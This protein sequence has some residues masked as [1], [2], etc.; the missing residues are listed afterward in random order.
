MTKVAKSRVFSL[1][2][3]EQGLFMN[4]GT[5]MGLQTYLL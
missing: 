4:A 2:A 5:T 1:F 3:C